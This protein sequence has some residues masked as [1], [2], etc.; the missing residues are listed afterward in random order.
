MPSFE[1]KPGYAILRKIRHVYQFMLRKCTLGT[2]A[3]NQSETT[4]DSDK[5]KR[6]YGEDESGG[7]RGSVYECV[8][9]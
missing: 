9:L 1:F 5:K 6:Q 3:E 4:R 2:I 7:R 8:A